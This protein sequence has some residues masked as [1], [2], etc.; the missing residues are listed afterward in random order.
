M[1]TGDAKTFSMIEN[2]VERRKKWEILRREFAIK[3]PT[4]SMA[5][6]KDASHLS[7]YAI[8]N[9]AFSSTAKKNRGYGSQAREM[10]GDL[11][12]SVEKDQKS[13]RSSSR[14][15]SGLTRKNRENTLDMLAAEA[16]L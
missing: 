13:R 11:Q 10:A 7:K 2:V 6:P 14:I 9:V 12:V 1:I 3:F 8:R 15:V 16:G 5:L 4:M